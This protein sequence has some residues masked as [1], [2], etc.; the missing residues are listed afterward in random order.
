MSFATVPSDT[1]A[2][3]DVVYTFLPTARVVPATGPKLP[4]KCNSLASHTVIAASTVLL[5][6]GAVREPPVFTVVPVAAARFE[7]LTV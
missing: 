1:P 5:P 4:A 3:H 6:A 2:S 7:E